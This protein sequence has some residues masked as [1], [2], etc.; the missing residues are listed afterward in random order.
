MELEQVLLFWFK[1]KTNNNKKQNTCAL[2]NVG[3]KNSKV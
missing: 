2:E 3:N 1:K